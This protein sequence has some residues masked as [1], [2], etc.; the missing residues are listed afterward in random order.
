MSERTFKLGAALVVGMA[1]LIS[2]GL[3]YEAWFRPLMDCLGPWA[4][5]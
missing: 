5:A 2:L 1:A 4:N 3:G